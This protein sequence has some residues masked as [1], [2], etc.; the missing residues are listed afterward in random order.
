[1]DPTSFFASEVAH[2]LNLPVHQE[3]PEYII[4]DKYKIVKSYTRLNS[5]I[6]YEKDGAYYVKIAEFDEDT[7]ATKFDTIA[8]LLVLLISLR[9]FTPDSENDARSNI[10]KFL[11]SFPIKIVTERIIL[12][13]KSSSVR[14]FYVDVF[15]DVK[16]T[17]NMIEIVINKDKKRLVL[18]FRAPWMWSMKSKEVFGQTMTSLLTAAA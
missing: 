7:I 18:I 11:L 8:T 9:S 5:I 12:A 16:I 2:R 14:L 3:D 15:I 17:F 1:M 13:S 6:T 4:G 10:S